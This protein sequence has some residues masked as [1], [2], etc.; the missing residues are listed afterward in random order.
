MTMT[1]AMTAVT[2]ALHLG[3]ACARTATGPLA[4]RQLARQISSCHGPAGGGRRGGAGRAH[5]A[6]HA[7]QPGAA[8]RGSN[9]DTGTQTNYL[10]AVP[11]PTKGCQVG[12]AW[13][14]RRSPC[15]HQLGK[16]M[17]CFHS[18]SSSRKHCS[19]PASRATNRQAGRFS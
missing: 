6:G 14:G 18:V 5:L 17:R 3:Q 1:M 13:E 7:P 15:Y 9:Q 8:G 19:A 11:K 2:T 10:R 12:I 16:T 4:G